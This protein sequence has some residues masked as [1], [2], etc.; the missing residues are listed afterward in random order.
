MSRVGKGVKGT[1]RRPQLGKIYITYE[2]IIG[3]RGLSGS[4]SLYFSGLEL[5]IAVRIRL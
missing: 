1:G 5:H 2:V 3:A 4:W